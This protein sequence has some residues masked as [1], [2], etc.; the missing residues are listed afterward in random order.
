M[1][2]NLKKMV[3]NH[4]QYRWF[5]RDQSEYG[6][7]SLHVWAVTELEPIR[8]LQVQLCHYFRE[9]GTQDWMQH[10]W[11]QHRS[12]AE[13]AGLPLEFRVVTI[14]PAMVRQ[15]IEAAVLVGWHQSRG[16]VPLRFEWNMDAQPAN[17]LIRH[18][19][20]SES[21]SSRGLRR[22]IKAVLTES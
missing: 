10:D 11:M 21:S 16:S 8:P 18:V 19:K 7:L 6:F 12:V 9:R 3:V 20:L 15:V 4:T 5:V 17:R 13:L 2:K 14:T 1:R 22:G